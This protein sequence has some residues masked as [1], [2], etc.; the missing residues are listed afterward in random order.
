MLS[1][2]FK[3]VL[4]YAEAICVCGSTRSR[5][6]ALHALWCKK[7]VKILLVKYSNKFE[8]E[9]FGDMFMNG[10]CLDEYLMFILYG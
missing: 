9:Y 2:L 8:W 3:G 7:K 1:M 4:Y 10:I 5:F 6:I